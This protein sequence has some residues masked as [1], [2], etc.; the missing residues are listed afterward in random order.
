MT[1]K[2]SL[3]IR[4]II[5]KQSFYKAEIMIVFEQVFQNI[6]NSDFQNTAIGQMWIWLWYF[7]FWF[8]FSQSHPVV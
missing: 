2:K 7:I 8:P 6:S 4:Q 3:I 5:K 1:V